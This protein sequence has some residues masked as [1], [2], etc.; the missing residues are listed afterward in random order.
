MPLEPRDRHAVDEA[1]RQCVM[2]HREVGR[3]MKH[4]REVVENLEQT[5]RYLVEVIGRTA[6]VAQHE[7]EIAAADSSRKVRS[8]G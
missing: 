3:M 1:H 5:D 4:L 2:A 7:D 6:S 8:D